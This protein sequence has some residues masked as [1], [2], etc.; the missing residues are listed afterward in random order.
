MIENELLEVAKQELE[1]LTV[2]IDF[3]LDDL[4]HWKRFPDEFKTFDD[5][6]DGVS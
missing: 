6:R 5:V 4:R 1:T 2:S 3:L